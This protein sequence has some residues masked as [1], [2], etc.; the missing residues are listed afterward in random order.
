MTKPYTINRR[1]L[2][3]LVGTISLGRNY[4]EVI[5]LLFVLP[6]LFYLNI[7]DTENITILGKKILEMRGTRHYSARG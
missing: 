4:R 2:S 7:L 1:F 5:I 6:I 3:Q